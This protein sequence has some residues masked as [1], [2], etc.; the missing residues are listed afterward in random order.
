MTEQVPSG[1]E[2]DLDD[3]ASEHEVAATGVPA[4]DQVLADVD[5]VDGL[6]LDLHQEAFER[7]HT[8][9]RSALDAGPDDPA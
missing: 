1:R 2:P 7:A 6:P 5:R 3:S 9:L 8:A 4:V